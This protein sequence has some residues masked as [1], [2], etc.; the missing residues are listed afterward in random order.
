MADKLKLGV[1]ELAEFCCRSGD[2]GYDDSPGVGAL[3]GLQTHQKIQHRYRAQAKAEI[4]VKLALRID[5]LDIELGGRI[6]L[7]F[8]A[9]TPPRIEEIKTVYAH[10]AG[11]A[12]DVI[13]VNN[14][15]TPKLYFETLATVFCTMTSP[16]GSS[17]FTRAKAR[18]PNP[19]K[20][21]FFVSK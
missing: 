8:A 21:F 17:A 6:D 18:A 16:R 3:Q 19:S 10:G 15:L 13:N 20:N 12:D 7:L 9:E 5:D 14:A 1:R 2:L 11:N 4:A